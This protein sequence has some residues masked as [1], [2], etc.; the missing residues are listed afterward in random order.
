MR[1]TLVD[2]GRS[3]RMQADKSQVGFSEVFRSAME[4]SPSPSQLVLAILASW[5]AAQSEAEIGPFMQELNT[6]AK[7]AGADSLPTPVP[8]MKV[9]K[10]DLQC[11]ALGLTLA[12]FIRSLNVNFS[13]LEVA[14]LPLST[15]GLA[16][17]WFRSA[18][19]RAFVPI[20]VAP[21]TITFFLFMELKGRGLQG[22]EKFVQ[23]SA[24]QRRRRL[25]DAA[26]S[27][28][29]RVPQA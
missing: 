27:E 14:L 25:K 28:V 26:P 7:T 11:T 5:S 6:R 13:Q 3:V 23:R 19:S 10:G 21:T 12:H 4:Q 22:M 16:Q 29:H 9:D 2:M 20:L 15:S 24:G 8:K 17:L 1:A 18:A